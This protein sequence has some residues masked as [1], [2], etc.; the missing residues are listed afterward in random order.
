M[1]RPSP[2]AELYAFD[3][4]GLNAFGQYLLRQEHLQDAIRAFEANVEIYPASTKA[5]DALANAR[6]RLKQQKQ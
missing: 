1:L 2:R 5:A 3:E 4:G 6:N